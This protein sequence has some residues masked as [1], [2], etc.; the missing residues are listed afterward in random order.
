MILARF[1]PLV[2]LRSPTVCSVGTA[3]GRK[4]RVYGRVGD[5]GRTRSIYTMSLMVGKDIYVFCGLVYRGTWPAAPMVYARF[6]IARLGSHTVDVFA[7][8]SAIERS[9][10][11]FHLQHMHNAALTSVIHPL[12]AFD[13]FRFPRSLS[14]CM[15]VPF[16]FHVYVDTWL[17]LQYVACF[18][19][20]HTSL[21][22]FP[23]A[24]HVHFVCVCAC[25]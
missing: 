6:A 20:Y 22:C 19:S 15:C 2:G 13:G 7:L 23:V 3:T 25:L 11:M 16:G 4:S 9:R 21:L 18:L 5:A 10:A 12:D 1:V 17:I 8:G 14:C 24:L